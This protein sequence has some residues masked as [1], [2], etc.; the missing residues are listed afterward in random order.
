VLARSTVVLPS[1]TLYRIASEVW[2]LSPKVL[3]YV[4]NGVDCARFGA[5][6]IQPIVWEGEGPVVGTV[7]A[8]RPEKNLMR[9]IE[10]FR[11]VRERM[12]CRLLIAGDGPER[13][14]LERKVEALGLGGSVRFLGYIAETERVYAGLSVLALSSD[15]EQMPTAVL[16][17]MAA[18]LSI[19][20]TDVGDV[21][22]MVSPPNRPFVVPLD[23]EAL[24]AAI[25]SLL[26]QPALAAAIG[27][28]NREAARQT[29]DQERMF[30]AYDRLFSGETQREIRHPDAIGVH[31]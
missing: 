29:F 19:V 17:G 7:A 26:L 16:E 11:Q 24:A 15:T 12:P 9:L 27:A 1:R 6:D 18:G 28:M 30:L 31:P 13:P 10:A 21:S 23:A 8:L 2:K 25:Q 20:S 5:P 3:R 22:Q 4:P 14:A